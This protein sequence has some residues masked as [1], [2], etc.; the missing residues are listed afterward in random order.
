MKLQREY[1]SVEKDGFF[2]AYFP[3]SNG[4]DRCMIA[5]LGDDIDDRMAVSG[6]KW[7]HSR[8]CN[9]MTM[10]PSKKDYGH[11]NYP[12]ERFEKAISVI[13]KKKYENW[14]C[15]SLHY[16]YAGACCSVPLL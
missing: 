10:A 7:L 14:Y 2:G 16:R 4:T 11:H 9:V 3:N 5:L 1:F 8:N 15:G 12:L 13:R 6:V